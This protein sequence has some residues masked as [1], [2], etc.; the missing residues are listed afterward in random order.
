M[1]F[2]YIVL[3]RWSP[4]NQ[5]CI[6][7]ILYCL[8]RLLAFQIRVGQL[9]CQIMEPTILQCM[10]LCSFLASFLKW[11]RRASY[12]IIFQLRF[13]SSFENVKLLHDSYVCALSISCKCWSFSTFELMVASFATTSNVLK[14]LWNIIMVFQLIYWFCIK[15]SRSVTLKKILK[16]DS[17]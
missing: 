14:M 11:T 2:V 5:A 13:F 1:I 7:F 10:F 4:I 17:Y 6:A 9:I 8:N 16:H 15:T 3:I 12:L